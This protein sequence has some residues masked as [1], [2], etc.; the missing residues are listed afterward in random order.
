MWSIRAPGAEAIRARL[1]Q[2]R[3]DGFS[4]AEVGATRT[5]VDGAAPVGFN[6]DENRVRLGEGMAVFEA[7]CGALRAWKMFPAPWTRIS[8]TDAPLREGIDVAMQANALGVWWLNS[9]RIVYLLD[10][11][12]PVR[13]FGFAYG[14]L[15]AHVEEGEERFSVELHADGSVWYDLRAFSRPRF[16]P[17]RLAKPVAR[18][19]QRRFARDSKAAMLAAVSASGRGKN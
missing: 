6:Y 8:P 18:G 9:A 13:R 16:W 15:R 19:L 1:E 2:Q 12:T 17:V 11:T 3:A 14:T 5:M 10:E 7:A 4:Y